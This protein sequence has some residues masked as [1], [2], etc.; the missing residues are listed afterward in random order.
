MRDKWEVVSVCP[1]I[2]SG[3]TGLDIKKK[4]NPSNLR[5]YNGAVEAAVLLAPPSPSL[6][7]R[8]VL[9]MVGV[10]LPKDHRETSL[11]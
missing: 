3:N 10:G 2:M 1:T 7:T 6:V 11:D 4:K 8:C 5:E 9:F